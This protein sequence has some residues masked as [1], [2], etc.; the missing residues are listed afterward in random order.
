MTP[1]PLARVHSPCGDCTPFRSPAHFLQAS[2]SPRAVIGHIPDN[3]NLDALRHVNGCDSEEILK[4]SEGCLVADDPTSIRGRL[5]SSPLYPL[6]LR[7]QF[8]GT[9]KHLRHRPPNRVPCPSPCT[10]P[11]AMLPFPSNHPLS[12]LLSNQYSF[13][14]YSFASRSYSSSSRHMSVSG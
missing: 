12:P 14:G 11:R 2:P 5:S 7:G 4:G 6:D 9:Q 3:K 8:P 1:E 13:E 10:K